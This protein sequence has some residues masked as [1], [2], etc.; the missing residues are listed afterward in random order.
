MP[1]AGGVMPL[2]FQVRPPPLQT[3][4]F[5]LSRQMD[6]L[7]YFEQFKGVQAI[8]IFVPDNM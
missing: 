1:P 8:L 2:D 6:P 5:R 7:M 4:G 3:S